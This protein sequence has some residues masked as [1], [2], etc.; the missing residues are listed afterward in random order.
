MVVSPSPS[1]SPAL[2]IG[3]RM[4]DHANRL[5]IQAIQQTSIELQHSA[6]G[7][8]GSVEGEII[9][10]RCPSALEHRQS[11]ADSTD[12]DPIDD[13]IRKIQ[14]EE[15]MK[16]PP[17]IMLVEDNIVNQKIAVRILQ[18]A[19][20]LVDVANNGLE[21]IGLI[22]S[23]LKRIKEKL[24]LEEEPYALILMDIEMPVMNGLEATKQ[25]RERGLKVHVCALTGNA[26]VSERQRCHE[27]GMDG[28]ITKPFR[29]PEL[30]A[31]VT[32]GLKKITK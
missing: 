17:R 32:E 5:A 23:E 6:D 12:I 28:F 27:V 24:T 1:A 30:L 4:I 29:K 20:Y 18:S 19:G 15:L 21:A 25:I 2:S 7:I 8:Q 16:N 9:R 10:I 31:A 11:S 22:D 14:E 3:R 13:K 26:M